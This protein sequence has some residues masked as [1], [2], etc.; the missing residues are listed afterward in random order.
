M[1]EETDKEGCTPLIYM[2]NLQNIPNPFDAAK[3]LIN[4]GML[5]FLFVF[6]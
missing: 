6:S 1:C 2:R 4:K 3:H 5:V